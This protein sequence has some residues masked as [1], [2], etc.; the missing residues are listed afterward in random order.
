MDEEA[1]TAAADIVGIHGSQPLG[2]I[3]THLV[4]NMALIAA[5]ATRFAQA[6][7]R[8]V[9]HNCVAVGG[10][11]AARVAFYPAFS[12]VGRPGDGR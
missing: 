6:E 12:G 10:S 9:C 5:E 8:P 11:N 1:L 2:L 3:R 7:D 4:S